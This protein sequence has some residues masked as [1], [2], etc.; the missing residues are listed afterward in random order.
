MAKFTRTW[1]N[2]ALTNRPIVVD[3][4]IGFSPSSGSFRA[5]FKGN[6]VAIGNK[7]FP[8]FQGIFKAYRHL[9]GERINGSYISSFIHLEIKPF[10]LVDGVVDDPMVLPDNIAFPV[11]DWLRWILFAV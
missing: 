7:Q 4:P 10:A 1:S 3:G 11:C 6:P 5:F 2:P 9:I 8:A